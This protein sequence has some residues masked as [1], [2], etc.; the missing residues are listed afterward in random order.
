MI[1]F[2]VLSV[3]DGRLLIPNIGLVSLIA[4]SV[5]STQAQTYTHLAFII[6]TRDDL[7][8]LVLGLHM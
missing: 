5:H 1:S 4:I 6:S 8:T 2:K 3:Q 7:F